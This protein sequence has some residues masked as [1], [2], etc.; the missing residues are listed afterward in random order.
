LEISIDLRS[1]PEQ[2]RNHRSRTILIS[3]RLRIEQLKKR[4]KSATFFGLRDHMNF[5]E[6]KRLIKSW[7]A[8]TVRCSI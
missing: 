7:S 3:S 2:G 5:I 4:L 6:R 8:A 1:A